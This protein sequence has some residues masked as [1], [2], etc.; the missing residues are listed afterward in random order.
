MDLLS[1]YALFSLST[2]LVFIALATLLHL[3]FGLAGIVNVGVVGFWGLGMYAFGVLLIQY[4]VPYLLAM[5]LATLLVGIVAAVIGWIVLDLDSDAV[6]VATIAFATVVADLVITEKWLTKGVVGLG[7][8]PH[9]IMIGNSA[10]VLFLILAVVAAAILLY[11]HLVN[12]SPYGRLL[13]AIRDNEVLARNLG[14]AASRHKLVFFAL[15][16]TVMGFLGTLSAPI[17]QFLVPD[18]CS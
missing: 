6:L 10:L 16:C 14:K 3:Q 9:P 13:A 4:E 7:T 12:R 18:L 5:V 2:V 11:A 17:H 1:G 15:T 8:V